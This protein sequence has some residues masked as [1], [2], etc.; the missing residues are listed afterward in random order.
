[1]VASTAPT[2]RMFTGVVARSEGERSDAGSG[3]SFPAEKMTTTPAAS[4]LSMTCHH[5][6]KQST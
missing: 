1:L 6:S 3:P 4:Q 5:R 2:E